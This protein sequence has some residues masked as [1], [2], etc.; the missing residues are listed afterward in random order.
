MRYYLKYQP[1]GIYLHDTYLGAKRL[2]RKWYWSETTKVCGIE[3]T[4]VENRGETTRGETTRG[5]MS[6]GRNV[7]LPFNGPPEVMDRNDPQLPKCVKILLLH[8]LAYLSEI[9]S[10]EK[11]ILKA[12]S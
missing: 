8:R 3:T 4:R 5:E 11:D 12:Y 7:L 2:G 1:R 10:Q 9:F 6:W